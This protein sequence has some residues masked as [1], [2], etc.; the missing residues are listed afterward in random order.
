MGGFREGEEV[1]LTYK[2]PTV[3]NPSR[4]LHKFKLQIAIMSSVCKLMTNEGKWVF[5]L[6][7]FLK[8]LSSSHPSSSLWM[9]FPTVQLNDLNPR[10]LVDLRISQAL[11]CRS[12]HAGF[13]SSHL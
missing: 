12:Q 8:I 9:S 1:W 10:G 11:L 13:S 6:E 4:K 7:V 2:T 3:N 5:M